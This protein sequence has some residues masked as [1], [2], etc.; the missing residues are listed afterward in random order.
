MPLTD[1]SIKALKP[2]SKLRKVADSK[3]LYVLVHPNGSKYWRLKY[4]YLGKEKTLA[5]GV[6]PEVTL[7][8]AREEMTKARNLL[9]NEH[10][11]PSAEKRKKRSL[12]AGQPPC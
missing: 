10:K 3:G 7:L 5:I 12:T 6:Y 1:R 8:K 9:K 4:R 2:G 11:D